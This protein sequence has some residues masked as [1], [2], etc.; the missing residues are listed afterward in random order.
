MGLY[1]Q[2]QYTRHYDSGF[3]FVLSQYEAESTPVVS[4]TDVSTIRDDQWIVSEEVCALLYHKRESDDVE[5]ARTNAITFA[6][7]HGRYL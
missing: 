6:R 3:T 5:N 2:I 1:S 4:E 7:Y